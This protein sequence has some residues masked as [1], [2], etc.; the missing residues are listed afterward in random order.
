MPSTIKMAQEYG[1][2]LAVIFVECQGATPEGMERFAWEHGWMGTSAMWT[3]ER[4]F[5]T[6]ARGL[7]NFALLGADGRLIMKGNPLSLHGKIVDAVEEEIKNAGAPPADAP[8]ALKSAYKSLSKGDFAKAHDAASDVVA[9]GDEDAAAANAFLEDLGKRIDG[10]FARVTWL[11]DNGFALRAEALLDELAGGV[12]G[13]EA[14]ES[15]V[16]ELEATFDSDEVQAELDADKAYSKLEE[17]LFEDGL[18]EKLLKKVAKVVEKHEGTK[19]AARARRVLA[20][21]TADAGK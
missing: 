13:L 17:K 4:V 2:D 18:D 16:E 19:A 5:D 15:R 20:L 12:K 11:L 1:D 8:K 9:D 7:P 21:G 6:G 14:Y 10:R 3:G